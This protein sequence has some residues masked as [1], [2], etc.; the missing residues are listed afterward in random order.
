MAAAT[1]A[2]PKGRMVAFP[3]RGGIYLVSFDPTVGAGIQKTRPKWSWNPKTA[4]IPQCHL[5]F[6]P[7][8][9]RVE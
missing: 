9:H 1:K 6:S 4:A 5:K 8:L 3:Q 7:E 2:P